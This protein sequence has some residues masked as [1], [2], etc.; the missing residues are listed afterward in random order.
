MNMEPFRWLAGVIAAHE[1]RK[2]VG[3]TRLQKEIKLL[4][5]LGLPTRYRYSIHFY[6]PY[7]EGVQAEIG[8]LEMLGLAKEEEYTRDG[9]SYFI[10]EATDEAD[11]GDQMDPFR[12]AIA[13]MAEANAVVLELAATYDAFREQGADHAE[14]TER[15]RRKKGEKCEEGREAKALELLGE[16]GLPTN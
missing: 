7:S 9:A 11:L 4:Q 15:L 13:Q 10:I 6:G 8:V 3:R 16:L 12:K 5:R 14:A 2:I 1:D